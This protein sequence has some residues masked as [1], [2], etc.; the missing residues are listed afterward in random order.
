VT[1]GRELIIWFSDALASSVDGETRIVAE[2]RSRDND[3]GFSMTLGKH[4]DSRSVQDDKNDWEISDRLVLRAT[5]AHIKHA[6]A[7]DKEEG[8]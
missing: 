2:C 6:D 1:C 3:C 8:A 7:K 5:L 4:E